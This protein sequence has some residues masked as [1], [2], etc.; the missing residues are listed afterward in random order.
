MYWLKLSNLV[1]LIATTAWLTKVPD[2]EPVYGDGTPMK[3]CVSTNQ[4]QQRITSWA[5]PKTRVQHSR[6]RKEGEVP[7]RSLVT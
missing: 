4:G 3:L 7:Y 2:W 5:C 1:M 6:L